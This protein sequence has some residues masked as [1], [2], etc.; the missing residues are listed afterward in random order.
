M[1]VT[2]EWLKQ[3]A[4]PC[5]ER[6]HAWTRRQIEALGVTYPPSKGWTFLVVGREITD[7]QRQR[8]EQGR[9]VRPVKIVQQDLFREERWQRETIQA[10]YGSRVKG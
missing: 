7:E 9:K 4:T 8:F 1:Q 2:R 6:R 5:G 3:Y 10:M